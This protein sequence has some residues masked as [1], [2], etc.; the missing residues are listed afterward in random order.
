MPRLPKTTTLLATALLSACAGAP[1]GGTLGALRTAEADVTEVRVENSLEEAIR[2]YDRFLAEAPE[3]ELTPEAMRRLADLQ[4][5]RE[6]GLLGEGEIARSEASASWV[7][8]EAAAPVVTERP[9]A[10][11]SQAES[12]H[13]FERRGA[14]EV[15]L[16]PAGEWFDSALPETV[17]ADPRPLPALSPERPGALPEGARLRRARAA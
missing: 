16:A 1:G 9:R 2:G 14:E 12:T 8:P 7:R 4:L 15:V 5:E 6:F 11:A 13:D 10:G 17:E 3:S